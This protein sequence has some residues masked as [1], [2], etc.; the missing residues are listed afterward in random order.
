MVIDVYEKRCQYSGRGIRNKTIVAI[1]NSKFLSVANRPVLQGCR[2]SGAEYAQ[3]SS[4]SVLSH[5]TCWGAKSQNSFNA[6]VGLTWGS[7]SVIHQSPM[8]QIG[9]SCVLCYTTTTHSA[10]KTWG[11]TRW[12]VKLKLIC[13]KRQGSSMSFLMSTTFIF[14]ILPKRKGEA[15]TQTLLRCRKLASRAAGPSHGF[16]QTAGW[17]HTSGWGRSLWTGNWSSWF[18]SNKSHWR[19]TGS[20]VQSEHIWFTL[21][22]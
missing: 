2:N 14:P 13:C 5:C 8:R 10:Q 7:L 17:P 15:R 12:H 18:V 22:I 16:P 4:G 1:W 6:K 3:P 9:T 11:S 21:V 20:E 19:Q